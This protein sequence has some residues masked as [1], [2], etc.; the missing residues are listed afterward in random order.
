MEK[1]EE[2][3]KKY[4]SISLRKKSGLQGKV[5]NPV[6]NISGKYKKNRQNCLQD[7]RAIR[8]LKTGRCAPSSGSAR[9]GSPGIGI[10]RRGIYSSAARRAADLRRRVISLPS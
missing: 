3:E 10:R 7:L 4:N 1:F 2:I 6:W 5:K 9:T 8:C